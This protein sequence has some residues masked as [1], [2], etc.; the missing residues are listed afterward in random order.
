MKGCQRHQSQKHEPESHCSVSVATTPTA[1]SV[2]ATEIEELRRS[3]VEGVLGIGFV[4]YPSSKTVQQRA[5]NIFDELRDAKLVAARLTRKRF[6]ARSVAPHQPVPVDRNNTYLAP[7]TIR[8]TIRA[9]V[10][11]GFAVRHE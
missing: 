9:F 4:R 3:R 1:C 8:Q 7:D 5:L 11:R 10:A 6:K 2:R